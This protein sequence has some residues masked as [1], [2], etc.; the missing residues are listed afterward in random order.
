MGLNYKRRPRREELDADN[1]F[2]E[3]SLAEDLQDRMHNHDMHISLLWEEDRITEIEEKYRRLDFLDRPD[4][5]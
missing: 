5:R 4:I 2:I 1:I 3:L